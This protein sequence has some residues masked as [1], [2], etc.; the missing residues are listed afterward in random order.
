[1]TVRYTRP[2]QRDIAGIFEFVARGNPDAARRVEDRIR[3]AGRTLAGFPE[4]GR[5]GLLPGTREWVV[6]GLPYVIVYEVDPVMG[7]VSV[8]NVVHGARGRAT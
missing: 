8:L 6:R 7:D 2:A 4:I 1:M 3:K 5:K